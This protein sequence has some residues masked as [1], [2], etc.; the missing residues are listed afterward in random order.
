MALSLSERPLAPAQQLGNPFAPAT[1]GG[2]VQ[3]GKHTL[4]TLAVDKY[5]NTYRYAYAGAVALV[6]GNWLQ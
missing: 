2:I 5:G 4:G 6:S 3:G 1:I